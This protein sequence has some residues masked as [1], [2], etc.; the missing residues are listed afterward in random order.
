MAADVKE[1][2]NKVSRMPK[3]KAT[4][5]ARGVDR[6]WPVVRGDP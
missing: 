4:V 6:V 1:S 2:G 5:E 3:A